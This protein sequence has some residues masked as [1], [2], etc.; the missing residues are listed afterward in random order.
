MSG[1]YDHLQL[2]REF[3]NYVKPRLKASSGWRDYVVAQGWKNRTQ[4]LTRAEI[5]A[6]CEALGFD[7]VR[8]K[9]DFVTGLVAAI[10]PGAGQKALEAAMDMVDADAGDEPAN[11]EALAHIAPGEPSAAAISFPMD[12]DEE[13]KDT[14]EGFE[15][16]DVET[17]IAEA[18]AAA[19]PHMTPHLASM[20]PGL[21][22]PLAEAATRG[23]R[24][25]VKTVT[26]QGGAPGAP[27][28]A[29][30]AS[31]PPN[32]A[33]RKRVPLYQ[34]FGLRKG[35]GGAALKHV[36]ETLLVNVC[37]YA[38]APAVDPDYVWNPETL[39]Q[40]AAQDDC[41]LNAWIFGPAGIGKTD[42]CEQYAA[43]L[44]RPF[45]R[46]AIERT[47]EPAELIGQMVPSKSGGMVWEDGK[48]TRAFRIAHCVI[49]IDEPTLLRSGTLAV[50][51]T[52]L[53][54]RRL[55]LASGEVVDAAPGVFVIAADNTNGTGDDTGRYVDTAPVNAAFLDRFAM[56][57]EFSYLT[58]AQETSMLA[59][60]ASVHAAIAKPMVDYANLTRAQADSGKLTMGVT[61]R[62][63]LAW[64]RTVRVG[65]PSAKAFHAIIIAAAAPEDRAV[66]ESLATTSLA[67]AHLDIDAIVRGTLDPDAP[68]VDPHAQGSVGATALQFPDDNDTL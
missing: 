14:G 64:A 31:A 29:T 49:L 12:P 44:A 10:P 42:G 51:Q 25:I 50:L 3:R 4:A 17:V 1:K 22:R 52:A 15:G 56:R 16:G 6:A 18:L 63:L 5:I 62:R 27:G 9:S 59:H 67:S 33:I 35:E 55:W 26:I 60:R 58:A 20:M 53:D 36:L 7:L 41:G 54:K 43:R 30:V 65:V 34:A 28:E 23:P 24:T 68:K 40:I 39:A 13:D 38:G 45:V 11:V 57:T 21:I 61:P 2:G 66:L 19:S 32:V 8:A 48:L 46:I 47:T 37:D